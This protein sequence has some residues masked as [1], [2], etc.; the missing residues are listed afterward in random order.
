MA[1]RGWKLQFRG[2]Q[3]GKAG[4]DVAG[5]RIVEPLELNADFA[6]VDE[7]CGRMVELV[8]RQRELYEGQRQ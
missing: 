3:Q 1:V 7:L 8:A 4:Q 2:G 5:C 6:M